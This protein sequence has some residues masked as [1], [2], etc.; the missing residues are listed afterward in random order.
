MGSQPTAVSWSDDSKKVFF[1]WNPEAKARDG[2]YYITPEDTKP[3]LI[4][5][6]E[7]R[8]M[9]AA[10][11]G[12]WNKKH[13]L[14]LIEKQGDIYIL[15]PKTKKETQLTATVDRESAPMWNVDETKVFYARGDNY[16]AV[17]LN[18]GLTQQLTNFIRGGA[19]ATLPLAPTPMGA[20][21]AGGARGGRQGQG[22]GAAGQAV[23]GRGGAAQSGNEQERWLRAQQMDLFDV[24]KDRA[25]RGNDGANAGG[26]FGR[27][28]AGGGQA[29]K[30]TELQVE[31]KNLGSI[32]VSPDGQYVTYRL[33]KFADGGKA[34][35]VPSYVTTSGFTEDIIS[36]TKVGAPLSTSEMFV[37]DVKRDTMYK[38][39]VKEIPGIKDLPD[40]VKE[41]PKQLEERTKANADRAVSMQG[42]FW[43]EDGKNGV[44]IVSAQDN[45]DRWIMKLNA[46]TGK[47]SLLDRQRDEAW[48]GG[49]GISSFGGSV[50]WLDNTHYY[51]QS[52]ATGYS[53]IYVVDV[54]TGVKKQL[55]NGKWEVSGLKLS[56]DKK[57]FYF[58]GNMDHPGVSDYFR[59]PVT[60]GTPVKLTSLKGGNEVELSPDEKWLAIRYSY[61]NKP[62]EL[63]IQANKAGAKAV[64]VTD[65]AASD[66]FKSYD[67]RAPE[68]FSFKNRGGADIYGRVYTPKNPL[69][70]HP[71]VVFVHGAGYLQDVMYKWS[72][73]YFREFMFNN[74]LADEGYTVLEI[75]YTASAGYGRDI[76]TGIY[77]HMGGKDLTDHIDAV[78]ILVDKYGVNP[79][80]VGMYGGSYGGFMTLMALFTAP[81]TFSAG[82]ALRS[83]TDWAHYNHG[84][85]AN[86]LNEPFND[87]IA[88]KR[89]SPINFA[90]GLKGDLLMCHG[91][92]DDNVNYQDII[93]L[94][95]KLIELKKDNW[96][97]ASYP[98]E[99]HG[100]IEPSSWTDEYKRIHALFEA[101]LK[102]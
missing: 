29:K 86:I 16:Y 12:V 42:P 68:I 21:A 31:D 11:Q 51:F 65:K 82:A 83:V 77:R 80:N 35:I 37:Y 88:Y 45:K 6:E 48:I 10:V 5:P 90:N 54:N 76:R 39:S 94:N 9:P 28:S 17:T 33:T 99:S 13:T 98:L 22:G 93:R 30:M 1:T 3:K 26:R 18:G 67:W 7:R 49:P 41:Y 71:A 63:F 8:N 102:K 27:A 32:V 70:S 85:T 47:L 78:K 61:T 20:G 91:M 96:S 50:G 23:A 38:V 60:G 95:Q 36:R 74:M 15:D 43:S 14:Q 92:I 79:K 87:E 72:T 52:E 44:V 81:E 57:S 4:T 89:S 62:Y 75:D 56:N 2:Q 19:G 73:S 69:P 64:Q 53:H 55:T 25:Q 66:E 58:S 100:F 24:L 34:T 101:S 59:L 46:A 97:L 40:Y 84:Y